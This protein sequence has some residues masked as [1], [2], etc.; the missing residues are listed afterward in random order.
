LTS[1]TEQEASPERLLEIVRSEWGIENGLH[2]RRDVTFHE[3]LTR[4]TSKTMGRAM[5]IINNLVISLLNHHGFDNHARARRF[6]SAQP[7]KA[8]S[9]LSGL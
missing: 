5:A 9:I 4:M 2:Y 6:F 3:D 1:L 8:F 7:D